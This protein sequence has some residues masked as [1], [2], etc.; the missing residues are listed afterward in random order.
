MKRHKIVD[1]LSA[2]KNNDTVTIM[3]W[4]RTRRDS[5]AG[6]SFIEVNDGSCLSNIQVIADS[7]LPNY[8]DDILRLQTGSSLKINGKIVPSQGKGQS[9]EVQANEIDVLGWTDSDYPLQKKRPL[10]VNGNN[11]DPRSCCPL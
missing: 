8:K 1:I 11:R 10:P 5:K 3:G 6:F 4:V 2:E 9:V 7:N